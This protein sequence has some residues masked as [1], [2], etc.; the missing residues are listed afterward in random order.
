MKKL[1]V[2]DIVE[3]I[4][5]THTLHGEKVIITD[6][7]FEDLYRVEYQS[8]LYYVSPN[9]IKIYKSPPSSIDEQWFS[10]MGDLKVGE[11]FYVVNEPNNHGIL[12][13]KT[14]EYVGIRWVVND[15]VPR[16]GKSVD[17]YAFE[18]YS[19]LDTKY[20]RYV[21]EKD[22]EDYKPLKKGDRVRIYVKFFN[23]RFELNNFEGTVTK[24][25]ADGRYVVRLDGYKRGMYFEYSE[26]Q[27]IPG[28]PVEPSET[29]DLRR[30]YDWML[31]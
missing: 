5:S 23:K 21:P 20:S 10:I 16:I 15:G 22:K 28:S 19:K 3:I 24:Q 27:L 6:L 8:K 12:E 7:T 14:E 31:E 4:P 13:S 9:D 29:S 2:G 17:E 30:S 26:L 25:N 1:K 11:E 18:S